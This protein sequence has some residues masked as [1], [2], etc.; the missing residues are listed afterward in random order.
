MKG[1]KKNGDV[2]WFDFA[3][4]VIQYDDEL[5]IMNI[6]ADMTDRKLVEEDR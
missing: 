6:A 5:A 3:A 2:V 4:T 1:I